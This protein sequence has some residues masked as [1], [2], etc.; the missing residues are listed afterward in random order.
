MHTSSRRLVSWETLVTA[1]LAFLLALLT[2]AMNAFGA[3]VSEKTPTNTDGL[4][5][6]FLSGPLLFETSTMLVCRPRARISPIGTGANWLLLRPDHAYAEAQ[7]P[8]NLH[9][10]NWRMP[11]GAAVRDPQVSYDGC[12]PVQLLAGGTEQYHVQL[13]LEEQGPPHPLGGRGCRGG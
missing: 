8:P 11:T 10:P 12:A 2:L 7:S 4:L 1:L 6:K 9:A 5:A 3:A 13:E